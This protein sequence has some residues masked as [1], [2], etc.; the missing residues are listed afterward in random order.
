MADVKIKI[1]NKQYMLK[2]GMYCLRQLG[3]HWKLPTVNK[4]IERFAILSNMDT[5][6]LSFEHFDIIA[7]LIYVSIKSSSDNEKLPNYEDVYNEV[8]KNTKMLEEVMK[9]FVDSLPKGEK[10]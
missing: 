8:A 5:E 2:F 4:V 3:N 7:D 9:A 1:G 6:E 10:K